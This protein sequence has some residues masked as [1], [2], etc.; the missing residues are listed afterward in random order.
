MKGNYGIKKL[1]VG[2]GR[3]YGG[4]ARICPYSVGVVGSYSDRSRWKSYIFALWL[5]I[6]TLDSGS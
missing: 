4:V 6:K 1:Y 2:A 3:G 5:R